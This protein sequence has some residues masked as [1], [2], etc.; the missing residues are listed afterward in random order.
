[1]KVLI[2]F[3]PPGCGKGTQGAKLS[4]HYGI[5]SVS[6][7]DILR[8]AVRQG[9]ALGDQARGFMEKGQ[10]VPDGLMLDLIRERLSKDDVG[11]GFMLDGF[12]RTIPQAEGLEKV[13]AALKHKIDAVL[14]LVVPRAAL[15]DRL[16]SRRI[17]T[18]CGAVFNVRT[19]PPPP[20]GKCA[21]PKIACK[22][23]HITQRE[24]DKPETV[25]RRLDVYEETTSPL[26]A[27]YRER[28]LL[29]DVPGDLPPDSVF[30]RAVE[31][32]G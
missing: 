11:R 17:C 19:L 3:G 18:E 29:R 27:Y 10:L 32:V 13:L 25:A 20:D 24:D 22:G 28:G 7:G 6:T 23:E 26:V 16:T 5:P 21:D 9:T 30:D 1:M 14:N 15:M 31:R 8:E 4:A 2:L 12:P